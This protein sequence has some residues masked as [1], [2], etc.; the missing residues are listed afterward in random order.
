[1]NKFFCKY[2]IYIPNIKILLSIL[3]LSWIFGIINLL[4]AQHN[5]YCFGNMDNYDCPEELVSRDPALLNLLTKQNADNPCFDLLEF[6]NFPGE[7]KCDGIEK[8]TQ[9]ALFIHQLKFPVYGIMTSAIL[10]FRAKAVVSPPVGSGQTNTDFIAFFEGAN[11]LT[12]ANLNQLIESGGTWNPGQDAVFQLNLGNLPP[13]FSQTNLLQYLNDG[14]LDV[15]IGNETGVDWMCIDYLYSI[16]TS[17]EVRKPKCTYSLIP[18]KITWTIGGR[19]FDSGGRDSSS[20]RLYHL[21]MAVLK[22]TMWSSPN[23]IITDTLGNKLMSSAGEE[24][25]FQVS[26]MVTDK[27]RALYPAPAGYGWYGLQSNEITT[28]SLKKSDS[29]YFKVEFEWPN[30]PDGSQDSTGAFWMS[31]DKDDLYREFIIDAY[32]KLD[33]AQLVSTNNITNSIV[34]IYPNPT[35]SIIALDF[36]QIVPKNGTIQISDPLGKLLITYNFTSGK[37]KHEISVSKLPSGLYF[38]Y[39]KEKGKLIWKEKF[40]KL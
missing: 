22:P 1:M 16:T 33:A 7:S 2:R 28:S 13:V 23:I 37:S 34:R 17:Y 39:V 35:N 25:V 8:I 15:V 18:R 21:Q 40:I 11:Y 14:D 27:I 19:S 6:D 3:K 24:I 5:S 32:T 10:R 9:N 30:L 29:S 4:E 36:I 20:I 31:D 26:N 38:L 12:G